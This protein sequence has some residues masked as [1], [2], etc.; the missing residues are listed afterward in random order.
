LVARGYIVLGDDAVEI[1][2]AGARFLTAFGIALPTRRS[3]R[4]EFCRPC[5]D[6]T[7]RRPHIAGPL[8]AAMTERFFD[9]GW[10]ERA[11]RSHAIVVTPSGRRG[12]LQTFGIE[13]AKPASHKGR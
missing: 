9:L 11:K 7:E 1:T 3:D 12:L 5:L 8:G 6:W 2:T 13:D 10:I 4:Q